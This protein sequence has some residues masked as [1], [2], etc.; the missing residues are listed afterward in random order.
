VDPSN[1]P[2]VVA[3]SRDDQHRFSKVPAPSITLVAGH[4]IEGDAHA[5]ELI[6]HTYG[7]HRGKT[8]PNLRQVHLLASEL[9]D[10]AAAAGYDL[11]P[12]DLGE[13]VLT[14]G[15]DLLVLPEGTLLDLG[16]PVVRLTG[17][18]NPC[19]QINRFKPG[20]MK[21]VLSKA[22][23]TPSEKPVSLSRSSVIRKVGVMAVVETGGDVVPG[24]PISVTLPDEPHSALVPV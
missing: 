22:D 8:L 15:I 21:V 9:F 19:V 4:G 10:E 14:A 7:P 24:R 16:G 20:L 2:L 12:G 23:G 3:V 5:G 13:N 11:A 17:L 1:E 18:R 6:T